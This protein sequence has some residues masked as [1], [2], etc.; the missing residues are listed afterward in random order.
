MQLSNSLLFL[1]DKGIIHRDLRTVNILLSDDL[2]VKIADFGVAV[3]LNQPETH[4]KPFFVGGDIYEIG[5]SS[6]SYKPQFDT[7]LFGIVLAKMLLYG[8]QL[9]D[10]LYD[11][12]TNQIKQSLLSD[13][14]SYKS[15]IRYCFQSNSKSVLVASVIRGICFYELVG[16]EGI[17][18]WKDLDV[19]SLM[20]S[21]E[22]PF[23]WKRLPAFM[24]FCNLKVKSDEVLSALIRGSEDPAT[25]F[26]AISAL[27]TT[28][29]EE[30][31]KHIRIGSKDDDREVS[32]ASTSYTQQE[33]VFDGMI[34][35]LN[36]F[37][38]S[39]VSFG[40][41][42]VTHVK[43]LGN[44]KSKKIY[45]ALVEYLK[46]KKFPSIGKSEA[47]IV[48]RKNLEF[49]DEKLEPILIEIARF[50]TLLQTRMEAI[51][52]LAE[53]PKSDAIIEVLKEMTG[54]SDYKLKLR[55]YNSLVKTS[56]NDMN[57]EEKTTAA[58]E[59]CHAIEDNTTVEDK[60]RV[61]T[62][63][64]DL[65]VSDEEVFVVLLKLLKGKDEEVKS[66]AGAALSVLKVN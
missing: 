7:R 1:H 59:L 4:N 62:S 23:L 36:L 18:S 56:L 10:D 25:K 22:D 31:L 63:L 47:A 6:D 2:D 44:S 17:T 42:V 13:I 30:V 50:D 38:T 34:K 19:D 45:D 65:A 33:E 61:T 55:A 60:L 57:E 12:K 66:S 28:P 37:L 24:Q 46:H 26:F 43:F 9:D 64:K 53:L 20:K 21:L 11:W 40:S 29:P 14:V 49:L 35:S 8:S 3:W 39:T 15:L 54:E 27:A 16:I 52:T 5:N 32:S 51:S 58:L 48:I 41:D